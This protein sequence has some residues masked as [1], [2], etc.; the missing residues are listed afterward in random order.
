[1]Y[2][3]IMYGILH[4]PISYCIRLII[5]NITRHVFINIFWIF[6]FEFAKGFEKN[7]SGIILRYQ[8]LNFQITWNDTPSS[9]LLLLSA[10][11]F[12]MI[13]TMRSTFGY[14]LRILFLVQDYSFTVDFNCCNSHKKQPKKI[15]AAHMEEHCVSML[16]RMWRVCW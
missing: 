16:I 6:S 5:V 15:T 2:E 12:T 7:I 8:V 10:Y 4:L 3:A 11:Y 1:M 9:P 14:F 13:H